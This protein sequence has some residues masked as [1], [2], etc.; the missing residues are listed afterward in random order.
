MKKVYVIVYRFWDED[1]NQ[2]IGK[3]SQ[4]GYSC[5]EDAKNFCEARATNAGRTLRPIYFQNI[6][7]N[8]IH[9]EFY[10]HAVTIK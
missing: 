4:E 7:S 6:T 8:G 5:Y 3:V 2:W 10:I 9:E 1:T